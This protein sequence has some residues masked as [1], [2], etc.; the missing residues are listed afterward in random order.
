MATIWPGPAAFAAGGVTCAST[1][2]TATAMPWGRPV[3]AAAS[4]VSEPARAP[5]GTMSWLSLV[6]AKSAKRGSSRARNSCRRVLAV[7]VDAL[8]A[9]GA[10]VPGL[11]AGELPDDPV[12]GLHPALGAGVDLGVLFQELQGLGELPLR[13]DLAAVPGDPVLA[14]LVGEGVDPVG[15]ALGG[16]VLPELGVGVRAAAQLGKRAQGRAVGERRQHGAGGEVGADADDLARLDA[17]SPDRRRHGL[18]D[19]V[20][21]VLGVLQ[22][23]VWRQLLAA[24]REHVVDHA[25][26]VLVHGAANLGA[27]A[28]PDDESAPRER[29]EVDPDDVL[30]VSVN[31]FWGAG[32][33]WR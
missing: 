23:P 33:G 12:G 8:V 11:G 20:E 3:Q 30:I 31:M 24:G 22:R 13:G 14:G 1:L 7:L 28:H 17:R 32:L 25:A 27:V 6:C 15:L 5:S 21:V 2:P 16:V 26:G 19:H 10:G 29:A 4:A 18:G 9:G